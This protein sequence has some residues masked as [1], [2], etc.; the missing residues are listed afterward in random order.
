MIY[1]FDYEFDKAEIEQKYDSA[2]FEVYKDSRKSY[3]WP[4]WQISKI[5]NWDYADKLIEDLGLSEFDVR[6][7][8]YWLGPDTRLSPH[9]DNNTCCSINYII[10]DDYAPIVVDGKEYF[11]KSCLL[12]CQITHMVPA[13]PLERKLF[14]LSI[15]D[16]S[17][18][19]V[20]NILKENTHVDQQ[21]D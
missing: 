19:D 12:N 13:Y 5:A 4:T 18:T 21:N 15:F 2:D 16:A 10:N 7:R 8:F 20:I 14:K 6:P 9:T 1:I 11:Y 17:Y 3:T